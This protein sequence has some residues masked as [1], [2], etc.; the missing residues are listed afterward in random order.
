MRPRQNGRHFA[1]DISNCISLIENIWIPIKISLKFVPGGPIN[2]IPALVQIMAWRRQGDKPLSGPMMDSLP[3]HICVTRPQW[4]KQNYKSHMKFSFIN[5]SGSEQLDQENQMHVSCIENFI[6]KML[7]SQLHRHNSRFCT[8]VIFK[9]NTNVI[10][11]RPGRGWVKAPGC[12]NCGKH[13]WYTVCIYSTHIL[14]ANIIIANFEKHGIASS[15][16]EF[17][18]EVDRSSKN[19]PFI[20]FVFHRFSFLSGSWHWRF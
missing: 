6:G 8:Y 17:P 18:L 3:T 20:R 1:D 13:I 15:R 11:Y 7:D 10:L 14:S 5:R 16:I 9:Q 19:I 2:N 12:A 4:V